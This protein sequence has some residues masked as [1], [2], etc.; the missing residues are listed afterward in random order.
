MRSAEVL[1][2]RES[3]RPNYFEQDLGVQQIFSGVLEGIRKDTTLLLPDFSGHINEEGRMT[4]GLDGVLEPGLH[5]SHD[6]RT[7]CKEVGQQLPD[8]VSFAPQSMLRLGR[9]NSRRKVFFGNLELDWFSHSGI[10]ETVQVAVKPAD[11]AS[12]RRTMHECA[13]YQRLEGSDIPSL[14]VLGILV[15][16]EHDVSDRKQPKHFLMTRFQ[17]SITTMDNLNWAE[18]ATEEKWQNL[19]PA[20]DTLIMLHGNLLFHGDIEFKNIATGDIKGQRV[21][22]DP[23]L[24]ASA[25][26]LTH[27][28]TDPMKLVRLMSVDFSSICTSLDTFV[29]S[30]LPVDER[31]INDIEKF[32]E[33]LNRVYLPYR[34]RLVKLESSNRAALLAA[35]DVMID[36]KARQACGEW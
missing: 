34:E 27:P 29:F 2:I 16:S 14:E 24:M 19:E 7:W 9:E 6:I 22:V 5:L 17:P 3:Q 33:L 4:E 20:L 12:L 25:R 15:A 30:K 18:L 11:A 28:S 13:M 1:S 32:E 31:P 21:V 10:H 26:Y 23:E 35:Y 8:R 36:Q